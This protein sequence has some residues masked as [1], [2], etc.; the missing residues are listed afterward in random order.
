MT[1]L[2]HY[3]K[4]KIRL[5]EIERKFLVRELPGPLNQ[6]ENAALEQGYLCIGPVV[7]VR[8][9]GEKYYLT[10]KGSGQMV[11]EEYNL[12]LKEKSYLHLIAKTDGYRIRKI[13]YRI[14]LPGP[15]GFIAELDVFTEPGRLV[16]AEV[17]F[18]SQEQA[19][20]FTPP[21]WFGEEVTFRREYHNSYMSRYGIIDDPTNCPPGAFPEAPASADGIPDGEN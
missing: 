11:R 3:N 18:E 15:E 21:P 19:E 10:Y 13:R 6:Y 14:P 4:E 5:M 8:Q 1:A 7:R 17:E 16:M 12:P 20:A 9:E 2:H